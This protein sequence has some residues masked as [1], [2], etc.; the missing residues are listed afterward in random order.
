VHLL[1]WIA[2]LRAVSLAPQDSLPEKFVMN[3]QQL[4][5]DVAAH[6][7][8]LGMSEQ[9][10]RL[11]ADCAMRTHFEKDRVIFQEG[12]PANRFYL[13]ERGKVALESR[14]GGAL[15]VIDVIG[16]G[17]LLGWSWLFPP[18]VWHF[19]ARAVEPTAAIFFYGT[20]LREYCEKDQSLGFELF[21]RMS[22]VMTRRLQSARA[23]LLRAYAAA[24]H[25]ATAEQ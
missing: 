8:L 11:V 24:P 22:E 21:K 7:F 2:R 14:A 3:R 19:A 25:L 9:H 17:D 10:I 6:P 12:D 15:V 5:A 18:Y 13:I 23:R 20:V 1:V 4:E 16:N